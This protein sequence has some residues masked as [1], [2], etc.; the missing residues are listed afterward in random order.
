MN[1]IRFLPESV[2]RLYHPIEHR[3]NAYFETHGLNRYATPAAV[4][5]TTFFTLLFGVTFGV[6][7][8]VALPLAV[9]LL[10]W[11]VMGAFLMR[12]ALSIV[13]DAAR[14]IAFTPRAW[15][16]AVLRR[17]ASLVDGHGFWDQHE[18][19]L[20]PPPDASQ[21]TLVHV[22][23]FTTTRGGHLYQRR[24]MRVLYPFYGL[25]WALF[26]EFKYYEREQSRQ[27]YA[28]HP[29]VHWVAA[30][31][32]KAYYLFYL[33]VVPA[34]VLP[35]PFWHVALGYGCMHLGSGV[36]ALFA[37][38][39]HE[40]PEGPELVVPNTDGA[41]DYRW[42]LRPVAAAAAPGPHPAGSRQA[43]PPAAQ[44]PKAPAT[45]QPPVATAHP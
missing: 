34:Q 26:R 45:Q 2:T 10:L 41:L 20:L 6:L 42:G 43:R 5:K 27:F 35:V 37:L 36:V 23:P 8:L 17:G 19:A 1:T 18:H 31:V 40:P 39:A 14:G 38:L 21:Y 22:T 9:F 16:K 13:H 3:V 33:L 7:L 12:A 32:S 28:H 25:V 24:H 30:F 44:A 4:G 29:A 11:F 15:V